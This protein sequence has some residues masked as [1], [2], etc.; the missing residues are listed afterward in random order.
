MADDD[1]I[2][3]LLQDKTIL[4]DTRQYETNLRTALEGNGPKTEVMVRT[5]QSQQLINLQC[6]K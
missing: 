1:Q 4:Y 3:T 6:L 2:K 5:W